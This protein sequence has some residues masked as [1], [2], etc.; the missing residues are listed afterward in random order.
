MFLASCSYML[1]PIIAVLR[2]NGIP[3]HNPYRKS[4]WILEPLRTGSRQSAANRMLALLTGHPGFGAGHRDWKRDDLVLWVEWLRRR[5]SQ[6]RRDGGS[7][8]MPRHAG[9][10]ARNPRGRFR[11]GC[12]HKACGIALRK[13]P[14]ALG[15]VARS[16]GDGIP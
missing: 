9:G 5:C 13:S 12:A 14:R 10:D 7:P 6:D 8:T 11:G 16:S 2:K 3:F 1:R 15:L 4:Q